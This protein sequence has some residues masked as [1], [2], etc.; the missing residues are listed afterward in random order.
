MQYRTA[1]VCKMSFQD[2]IAKKYCFKAS[3]SVKVVGTGKIVGSVIAY[4]KTADVAR[5]V[6]KLCAERAALEDN[7][8]TTDVFLTLYEECPCE[9]DVTVIEYSEHDD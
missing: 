1:T 3:G 4:D 8:E 2:K 6:E 7:L 5:V 9:C